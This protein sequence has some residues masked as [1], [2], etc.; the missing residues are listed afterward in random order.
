MSLHPRR[1]GAEDTLTAVTGQHLAVGGH[2]NDL[3]ITLVARTPATD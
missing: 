2:V 1:S 3:T